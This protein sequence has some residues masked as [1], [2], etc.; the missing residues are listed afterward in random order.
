VR[1]TPARGTVGPDLTHVG[2]RL[3]LAAGTLPNDAATFSRWIAVT[4]EIKPGAQMPAFGML[5]SQEL[6]VLAAYLEALQ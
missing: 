4:H 5:P 3:S 2:G 6:D 1:G